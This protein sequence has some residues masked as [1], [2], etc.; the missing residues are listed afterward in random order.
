MHEKYLLI[1][2]GYSSHCSVK[3]FQFTGDHS[4][5]LV[6]FPLYAAHIIV[7]LEVEIIEHLTNS[8]CLELDM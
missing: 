6:Y 3:F 7:P 4:I 2:D 8:Y 5:H 1:I